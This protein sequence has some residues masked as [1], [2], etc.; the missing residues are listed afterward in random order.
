MRKLF[1]FVSATVIVAS[2]AAPMFAA[3]TS[4]KGQV[5]DTV[6]YTRNGETDAACAVRCATRGN[7]MALL[8]GDQVYA[9]TGDY[10]K[11]K[12]AKLIEF[13]GKNVEAKGTVTEKDGK[14]MIEVTSMKA[15]Q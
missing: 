11:E 4:V 1:A 10:S 5:I 3:E 8:S 12:N 13:A 2:L 14:K 9:I 6:C 7:Q 15:A